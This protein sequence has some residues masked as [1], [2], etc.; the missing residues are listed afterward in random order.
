[1]MW[2][3]RKLKNRRLSRGHVLD[4]K[5][6]SGQVRATRLRLAS[7]ALGVTFGTFFGLYLLWRAG[8]WALDR[9]IY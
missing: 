9:L 1:M 6:R 3:R 8:E 5:L 7:V 2:F 4:V